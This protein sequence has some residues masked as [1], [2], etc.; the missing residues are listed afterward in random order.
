MVTF[1]DNRNHFT[2]EAFGDY[3]I[4]RQKM[5]AILNLVARQPQ[6]TIDSDDTYHALMLLEDMLPTEEQLG[7]F[8]RK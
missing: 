1:G 2:I 8:A 7:E 6:D 4:Y 5:V 3:S